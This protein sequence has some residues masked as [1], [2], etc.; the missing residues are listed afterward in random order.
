MAVQSAVNTTNGVN[1]SRS[2]TLNSLEITG[3]RTFRHLVLDRLGGVNLIVGKNSVG[4]SCLLEAFYLFAN[5][6]SASTIYHLLKMRDE[7]VG[8][9]YGPQRPIRYSD[10]S[11]QSNRFI[12]IQHLFYGRN[13]LPNISKE[14]RIGPVGLHAMQLVVEIYWYDQTPVKE[15]KRLANNLSDLMPSLYV[16]FSD[17]A[18]Q[19][20]RLE[21]E[22]FDNLLSGDSFANPTR[23][24]TIYVDAPGLSLEETSALWDEIKLRDVKR[25]VLEGLQIIVPTIEDID[26]FGALDRTRE[27]AI[28][29]RIKD[30]PDPLP[31]RSLGEGLNRIFGLTV[32]LAN[33]RNGLLLI[34]EIESGL[35][36]SVQLALWRLLFAIAHKLN[37]QIFATTH[38]WDCVETFQQ[39]ALEAENEEGLL[40]R[41]QKQGEEIVP[42]LFDEADLAIVTRDQIE[43]R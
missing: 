28:K 29:V 26:I 33:A 1:G 12:Q 11:F 18:E 14:I 37:V 2:L 27:P 4:K 15:G 40:I 25:I 20:Y 13:A 42:T 16:T 21:R 17:G 38:S 6:G 30:Y 22:Q 7:D 39:A 35:H 24:R 23:I 43:I 32:A 31:L 19:I 10:E 9:R 8:Q 5:Q 41:L 34:D 36:Y 3:F